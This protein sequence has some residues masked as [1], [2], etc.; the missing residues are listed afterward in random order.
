MAIPKGS[1]KSRTSNQST[2]IFVHAGGTV[3]GWPDSIANMQ[4][5]QVMRDGGFWDNDEPVQAAHPRNFS[6]TVHA[7]GKCGYC[8]GTGC[9]SCKDPDGDCDY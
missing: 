8:N 6:M 4:H 1:K 7:E 9:V 3:D 5:D 2:T